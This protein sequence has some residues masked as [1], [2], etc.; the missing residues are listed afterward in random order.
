MSIYLLK[1]KKLIKLI[2]VGYSQIFLSDNW[3]IGAFVLCITFFE[4]NVAMSGLLSALFTIAFGWIV[5]LRQLQ[6]WPAPYARNSILVGFSIGY[7]F[8]LDPLVVPMIGVFSVGTFMLTVGLSR[9]MNSLSIPVISLP[10]A[11]SSIFISL[12]TR[13]YSELYNLENL[14]AISANYGPEGV[15]LYI[16]GFFQSLSYVIFQRHFWVGALLGLMVLSYSR[17][18]FAAL[19]LGYLLGCYTEASISGNWDLSFLNPN[20]FNYSYA[21][22][23]MSAIFLIPSLFSISI[24]TIT[25]LLTVFTMDAFTNV[26]GGLGLGASSLPFNTSVI[27]TMHTLAFFHSRWRTQFFGSSPEESFEKLDSRVKRFGF[28]DMS[29]A[30]PFEGTW[31]VFQGFRGSMTHQGAWQYAIDFV[32]PPPPLAPI[33]GTHHTPNL[34]LSGHT[35]FGAKILSPGS[36][37]VVALEK[38]LPD[39]PLGVLN[40]AQNWGNYIMIRCEAGFH[41]SLCHLMKD[42]IEVAVGAYVTTGQYLAR[43]GNSGYSAIPHLHLQVQWQPYFSSPTAPFRI[44]AYLIAD[45]VQFN[46]IPSKG[47]IVSPVVRNRALDYAFV[48]PSG[49]SF[50]FERRALHKKPKQEI[51]T[52]YTSKDTGRS[53]LVDQFENTLYFWQDENSFYFYDYRGSSRSILAKMFAAS[54]RIPL[55]YGNTLHFIDRHPPKIAWGGVLEWCAQ[56]GGMFGYISKPTGTYALDR[57]GT[58]LVGRVRYQGRIVTTS[59]QIDP[60]HGFRSFKVDNDEYLQVVS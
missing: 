26:L 45:R 42:S 4:P 19:F 58:E 18:L 54:P 22:A 25:V 27:L 43:C 11:I 29:I 35:T 38:S 17:I 12:A 24:A 57:S 40:S 47:D 20:S 8:R 21:A 6:Q 52:V 56:L 39:N 5:G 9:F 13:H 51:V 48:W 7:I 15:P 34:E 14:H 46:G 28:P 23:C 44:G 30:L 55:T 37:Y 31:Q 53:C 3:K 10:F 32:H 41:V 36:G 59:A 16:K 33:E 49:R 1:I 60:N 50:V 2:L